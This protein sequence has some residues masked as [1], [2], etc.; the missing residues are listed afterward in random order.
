MIKPHYKIPFISEINSTPWNGLKVVE[1]FAGGGGSDIGWR[2]SGYNVVYANE[3]EKNPCATY[4]ANHPHTFLDTRDIKIV[5]AKEILMRTRLKVGEL[6]VLS[7]SPPCQGFSI[8]N[9][10]R[11]QGK[12]KTYENGITQKNEDLFFEY[13]RLLKGLMPKVFVAE[14]VKGLTIGKAKSVLGSFNLDLFNNQDETILHGL[15]NCG[16]VVRWQIL[17][18]ADY[19]TPQSRQRVFFIGVRKDLKLEPCFPIKQAY[20]YSVLDALPHLLNQEFQTNSGGEICFKGVESGPY[21]AILSSDARKTSGCMA[22]GFIKIIN[23]DAGGHSERRGQEIP[24][25]KPITT[26]MTGTGGRCGHGKTQFQIVYGCN[27]TG[28][29]K[30]PNQTGNTFLRDEVAPITIPFRTVSKVGGA[31]G[32]SCMIQ[33]YE[34][35]R[36]FTIAELKRLGGFPDDYELAG[37]YSK[38]W[39]IIGNSVAP[40]QMFNIGKCLKENIFDKL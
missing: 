4:R 13:I 35:R 33:E 11:L 23:G 18:A 21:P 25:D 7:G 14:N 9:Q 28:K 1:T 20:Q 30:R 40:P 15:M 12:L 6:D 32:V 16:Y 5:S 37:S 2:W 17:N 29:P 26:L 34:T 8:A 36:K 27:T 19:G 24:A 38:Q 10:N 3:F 31:G 39:E 22:T